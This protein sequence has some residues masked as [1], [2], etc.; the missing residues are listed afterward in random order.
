MQMTEYTMQHKMVRCKMLVNIHNSNT[1]KTELMYIKHKYKLHT[2]ITNKVSK[3][4]TLLIPIL[5]KK[6]R[7]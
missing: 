3:C 4:N 2:T 5:L 6:A 1:L 7:L